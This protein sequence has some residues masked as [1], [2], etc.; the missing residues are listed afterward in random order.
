[1][2]RWNVHEFAF[3]DICER[4]D[5]EHGSGINRTNDGHD[6]QMIIFLL[7]SL[8]EFLR[9]GTTM[10]AAFCCGSG[11]GILLFFCISHWEGGRFVEGSK[12]SRS[13]SMGCELLFFLI[14]TVFLLLTF[15]PHYF[16]SILCFIGRLKKENSNHSFPLIFCHPGPLFLALFHRGSCQKCRKGPYWTRVS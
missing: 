5:S 2:K 9:E 7:G 4:T 8:G 16:S 10:W 3:V 13:N 14:V 6:L 11:G 15:S 1:M 12:A